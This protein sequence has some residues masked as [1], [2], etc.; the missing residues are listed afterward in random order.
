M[1]IDD[2]LTNSAYH[3]NTYSMVINADLPP[4]YISFQYVHND[5]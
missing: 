4:F 5:Y 3:S 1:I 2:D